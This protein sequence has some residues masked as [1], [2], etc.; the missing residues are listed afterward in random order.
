MDRNEYHLP[1]KVGPVK[2]SELNWVQSFP[3]KILLLKIYRKAQRKLS[4]ASYM[5]VNLVRWVT[6]RMTSFS[7]NCPQ[8]EPFHLG[9]LLLELMVALQ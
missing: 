2:T 9:R 6:L 3:A 4:V 1:L 7:E 5:V 8:N